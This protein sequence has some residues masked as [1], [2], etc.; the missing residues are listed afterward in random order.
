MLRNLALA[1]S[2]M[3]SIAC[4]RVARE[5]P[6]SELPSV[7]RPLPGA[8]HVHATRYGDEFTVAYD[9]RAAYPPAATQSA[10][11]AQLATEW[12]PIREDIY[13]P[14]IPTSNVRGWTDFHDL[15][16][17]PDSWAHQW[18]GQWRSKGGD[19]LFYAFIYRSP[20]PFAE[21]SSLATPTNDRLRVIASI[22]TNGSP[23]L[24]PRRP[25]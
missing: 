14:G 4:L 20:G 18:L 11:E 13:N 7:L 9:L 16:T 24:P 23:L 25:S 17:S 15:T 1:A 2:L 6:A 5:I 21:G 19:V 12:S 10:V 22:A 3:L 8:E